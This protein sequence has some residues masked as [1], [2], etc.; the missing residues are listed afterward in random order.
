MLKILNSTVI[1]L[2]VLGF[3]GC[4]STS[5]IN[6]KQA[7]YEKVNMEVYKTY[8]ALPSEKIILDSKGT[9]VPKNIDA[10]AEIQHIIKTEMNSKGKQQVL[11]NPDFYVTYAAGVDLDAIK[12]KINKKNLKQIENVP[13]A[14][15]A[16][17]FIDA[18]TDEII[19]MSVAEGELKQNLSLEDR[20]KRASDAIKKMLA[21]L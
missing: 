16:I 15:L 3:N 4:V 6:V 1:L 19:W 5:D 10:N 18:K 12:E 20:K 13:S 17:V 7:K 11:A 8:M 14:G 21:G 2:M 9:W